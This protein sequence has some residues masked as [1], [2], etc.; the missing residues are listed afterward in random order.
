MSN[1]HVGLTSKEPMLAES[2]GRMQHISKTKSVLLWM[3]KNLLLELTVLAVLIGGVCG[4]LGRLANPS[5]DVIL[6]ISFPG[7]LLM[8]MLKMLILPLIISSLIG[9]LSQLDAKES[10]KM[11][12]R[13]LVYYF[14]TTILA[15][16]VGICCVLAIHPGDYG[17]K[18]ELGTGRKEKT[19]S[20][21]DAFLDLI[22]N[23]FPENL[24]QA[25][26]K[27]VKTIFVSKEED[28][29]PL[30]E[31]STNFLTTVVT[32]FGNSSNGTEEAK[33]VR[34]L[35]YSDGTNVLGVIGFCIAFGIIIGQ[36]GE[37]ARVMVEFFQVLSEIVMRLVNV[38]MWYSPFGI[39]CLIAGKI[40]EIG[41]LATTASQLGLYMLTVIVGLVIHACGTLSLIFFITTRKNPFKF[42][43]G[44]LQAWVMALGT[45]SSAATLPITFKCLE[46]NNGIDK[47][48]TRFVLPIGA[49]VNM[50][51]TA[52]YEAVAAIFIAQMNNVHLNAGEVITVS[53]TATLA[54][55]GAASVP[56]AGLVT[57]LLVLTAV[58]LPTKD[59]TLIVA[60]DWLLDRIRTSVNVIGDS[61]GAGI[62]YHL[63]RRELMEQ[64]RE[65][66]RLEASEDMTEFS[67]TP[68]KRNS[69][70]KAARSKGDWV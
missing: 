7:E 60:V 22:R 6:L 8:R 3:K 47:R 70:S 34:K 63:S 46:E 18:Q 66:E 13:S 12:T 17:I 48:V 43:R 20:T 59:I 21:M 55:I 16:I 26:F 42:F 29:K 30:A 23:L 19:V 14:G 62:V 2:E 1:N 41:D 36:M 4:F 61:F 25:C 56:S 15:A 24:V 35:V 51:G 69:M 10:G 65:R 5:P 39:M 33:P 44:F 38:I 45:A 31:N 32:P 68:L 40:M 64:D 37:R 58:G 28:L 54:S 11:G 52:L 67:E 50:D 27:Q 9:G 49:T 57:M 53:L